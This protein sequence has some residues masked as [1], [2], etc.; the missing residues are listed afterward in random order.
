MHPLLRFAIMIWVRVYFIIQFCVTTHIAMVL[1]LVAVVFFD[2]F[3][4]LYSLS[5]FSKSNFYLHNQSLICNVLDS[6]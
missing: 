6:R 4:V 1:F 2:F 5:C 3:H